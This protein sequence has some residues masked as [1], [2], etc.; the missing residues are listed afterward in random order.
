MSC[1]VLRVP[2][3][4]MH[5]AI[6]RSFPLEQVAEAHRYVEAGHLP[7]AFI[8][9]VRLKLYLISV[10]VLPCGEEKRY[11][12]ALNPTLAHRADSVYSLRA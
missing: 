9:R 12:G 8:T 6:D 5:R 4:P 11:V 1:D 7:N 10:P 3:L 2:I